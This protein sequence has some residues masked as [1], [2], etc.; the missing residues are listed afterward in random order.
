METLTKVFCHLT[1]VV[2]SCGGDDDND[3]YKHLKYVI[4]PS[5]TYYKDLTTITLMDVTFRIRSN[6]WWRC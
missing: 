2:E 1:S 6:I 3:D 5:P 4:I